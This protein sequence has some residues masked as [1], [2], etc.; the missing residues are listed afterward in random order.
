MTSRRLFTAF[1]VLSLTLCLAAVALWGRSYCGYQAITRGMPNGDDVSWRGWF[2]DQGVAGFFAIHTDATG[3]DPDGIREGWIAKELPPDLVYWLLN[4]AAW[5]QT[6]WEMG[7]FGAAAAPSGGYWRIRYV[8]L[9]AVVAVLLVLPVARWVPLPRLGLWAVL[10]A[11]LWLATMTVYV[12]G[13]FE[14]DGWSWDVGTGELGFV[15]DDGRASIRWMRAERGKPFV[16]VTGHR[17]W[18]PGAGAIP[19][20]G[21][22]RSQ[23]SAWD[24]R[25]TQ[26]SPSVWL[27]NDIVGFPIWL[28]S[29]A[30]DFLLPLPA[31]EGWGEG[32]PRETRLY[33]RFSSESALTPARSRA[34]ADPLASPGV[35]GKEA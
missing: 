8:P 14:G 15:L 3:G 23:Y 11:L 29:Y 4:N 24:P 13:H 10:S 30:E 33:L 17:T 9:W 16:H 35:E 18:S 7:G 1:S 22:F 2:L 6:G 25:R 31:G 19:S 26:G 21:I 34:V 12:R 28:P 5:D 32:K 27:T 20:F